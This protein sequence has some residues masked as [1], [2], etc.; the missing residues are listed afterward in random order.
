MVSITTMRFFFF[1]ISSFY[2]ESFLLLCLVF[3]FP[4]TVCPFPTFFSSPPLL[5]YFKLISP[6]VFKP[7][8]SLH[9]SSVR[10]FFVLLPPSSCLSQSC[11]S[12]CFTCIS[13]LRPFVFFWFVLLFPVSSL[14]CFGL[15]DLGLVH[16]LLLKLLVFRML[17]LLGPLFL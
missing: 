15:L 9:S 11:F 10:L 1:F 4:P 17:A 14:F 16:Q 13:C 3:L 12:S 8:F 7:V 5:H 2:F 6:C